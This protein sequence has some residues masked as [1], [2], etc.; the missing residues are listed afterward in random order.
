[1]KKTTGFEKFANKKKAGTI[2]EAYRQERRVE[3]RE[4]A[5]AIEQSFEEKR[6]IN[7]EKRST[8]S[9]GTQAGRPAAT[10]AASSSGPMP[11]NKFIAHAGV[12]ARRDAAELVKSGV[13]TVNGQPVN[14]PGFKVSEK[15]EIKVKGK[16]I[17]VTKNLIYILLNKPKDY[18]T[19]TEDPQGRKT[20][21]DL[22]KTATSER[23]YPVG[24]LDRNTSGVLLLTND[25][26]L[27]QTLSHPKNQ[28]KKIYE[29]KLDR[30][31]S[32]ADFE[33][34]ANGITLEDGFI[35]PDAI[36]Y[37]DPRDKSVIGIEI[38]SGRNRIVRRIFEHLRYDVKGLDRVTYAGLTKKN[39][40]RGKWRLLTEKE[41]RLLK[42]FN[43]D[44]KKM[45]ESPAS[46]SSQPAKPTRATTARKAARPSKNSGN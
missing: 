22:I 25:G 7:L 17:T 1:M 41:I 2:K 8:G 21:L 13:V 30:P 19:T 24:R 46:T 6:K 37:A 28:V 18:I 10:T 23:V 33:A 45:V 9:A 35:Q 43:K 11:L 31:V 44:T 15:D 20:V 4:R 12:C 36:G 39:V 38:H 14:E 32:K 40:N 34:I 29:V 5:Q 27:A 3:K 26:D 42:H 16:R